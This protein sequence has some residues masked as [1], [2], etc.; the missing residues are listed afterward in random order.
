MLKK[1]LNLDGT[2]ILGKKEQANVKGGY[3]CLPFKPGLNYGQC[4]R[5]DNP[6]CYYWRECSA[7][8]DDG[9]APIC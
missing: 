9:T 6:N 2:H 3:A 8:C 1:I 7:T 5:L 4:V